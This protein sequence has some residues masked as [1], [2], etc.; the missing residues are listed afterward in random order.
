MPPW[1]ALQ[2]SVTSLLMASGLADLNNKLKEKG[3][4]G[5]MLILLAVGGLYLA[6]R[7]LM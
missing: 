4:P 7:F 1:Q 6:F 3:M 2:A 5:W